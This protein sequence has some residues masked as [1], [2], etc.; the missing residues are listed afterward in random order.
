MRELQSHSRVLEPGFLILH[1]TS[2]LRGDGNGVSPSGF[3]S[4]E[5]GAEILL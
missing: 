1:V 2:S 3:L 4:S 5:Y